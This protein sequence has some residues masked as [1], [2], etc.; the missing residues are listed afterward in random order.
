M[1]RLLA[2]LILLAPLAR[3]QTNAVSARPIRP[4]Q[5]RDELLLSDPVRR[6]AIDQIYSSSPAAISNL[7]V[8]VGIVDG[9]EAMPHSNAGILKGDIKSTERLIDPLVRSEWIIEAYRK[10]ARRLSQKPS[11]TITNSPK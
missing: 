4:P 1:T 5:F 7:A 8:T 9:I 3:G 2:V 10:L 11:V 6:E